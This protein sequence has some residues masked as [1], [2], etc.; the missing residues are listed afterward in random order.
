M[1]IYYYFLNIIW[2][3]FEIYNNVKTCSVLGRR[4]KNKKK[5]REKKV[6]AEWQKRGPIQDPTLFLVV[7]DSGA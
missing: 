6:A 1:I 2:Y 5:C 3:F 7:S 4:R